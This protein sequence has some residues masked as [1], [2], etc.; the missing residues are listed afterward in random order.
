MYPEKM[1]YKWVIQASTWAFL[2]SLISGCEDYKP[3]TAANAKKIQ[4]CSDHKKQVRDMFGPPDRVGL[5][6]GLTSWSYVEQSAYS[7]GR[8]TLVVFFDSSGKVVDMVYNAP[9]IVDVKNTCE[10]KDS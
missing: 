3:L 4:I 5:M 8:R 2:L 10:E 1:S 6:R 7:Y 9:G